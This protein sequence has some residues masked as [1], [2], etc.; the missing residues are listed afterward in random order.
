LVNLV[1]PL[2]VA[3]LD[4]ITQL[5]QEN[6]RLQ[7]ELAQ[8]RQ[9]CDRLQA[10]LAQ[11]RDSEKRYRTLFELS[12]EGIVRFGYEQPI[13]I[14]L[15][16]EEQVELCYRSIYIAEANNA[17]ARI[18]EYEKGKDT[19][20][21]TLNDFHDR[22]SEITQAA[23]RDWIE[24]QYTCRSVETVEIDRHGRKRYFLNSAASTIENGCV[25]CT[26]MSQ[27]DIT[28]LRE[29]QQA[30]LE[31]EQARVAE[32]VKANEALRNAIAGLARLDNLDSFLAEMLKV[33]L[34]VSGAHGGAVCLIEGDMVRHAVLFDKAGWV[35]PE[36][37]A[38]RGT[39]LL[40]FSPELRLM[41]QRILESE[42]AWA[43]LPDDPLHPPS[44]Q[45]F[46]RE[47]GN[48]A[49]R[50][51]PMRIGNRLLGWLGL[52]F[53][54]EDPPLGRS[55]A[56]LRVLAEQMT[57]AVEMLRLAEEA[58][59]SALAK[60]NEVIACEREKAAT[61]RAAELAKANDALRRGVERLVASGTLDAALDA[62]LLEAMSVTE[63]AA[64]AILERGTGSEFIMQALAQDGKI[65]KPFDPHSS[66]DLY[67]KRTA[68][69]PTGVMRRTAAGEIVIIPVEDIES[70]F[71]EA[72]AYHRNCGHRTV[73]HFPFQVGGEV[74]GF[75]G[76][77]FRE[78]KSPNDVL[79][80]TVQALAHQASLAL[81]SQRLA[82]RAKLAAIAQEQ[83]RAASERAAELAKANDALKRS[84][85]H[86]ISTDSLRSFLVAVL[87][88]AI[89][90]CDAVSAAVF[91][92]NQ[93][94][95]NLQ[96]IAL[97]LHGEAI[98]IATDPRAE[99]WR[100]PIPADL[101]DAW[102]VLSQ[103][104]RFFW[105]D[106]DNPGVE[107]WSIS[108]P[109]HQQ[110][111]HKNI[112]T[113][114]LLIGEQALGFLGLCFTTHQQPSE[115][116]LE[117]CW[118]LAQHAALALRMSQLAEEAK[119]AAIAKE[120]EKAAQQR[121][122]ELA[123]ANEELRQRDRLLSAVAQ[124][125][126]NLL[127][128]EDVETAIPSA[129][130][131]VGQAA[132]IS[133]VQLLLERQAP[134]KQKLQHIVAYEWNALGIAPQ[135]DH[136][137]AAVLDN[138][139]FNFMIQELHLGRSIWRLV[140]DFPDPIQTTFKSI[141]IESSGTVPIFIEGRYIGG[142]GFDDC[143]TAR[144]WSQQE[145]D[146]LTTAAESIGAALHRK[147]LVERLIHE[148]ARAA[149]ERAAQL[150]KANEA[151]KRSLT[152]LALEPSLDKLL[153]YVLQAI[154][155]SLG[156]RSGAVYLF[157]DSDNTT[158]L[159]LNYE[160]GQMQQ[161]EQIDHPAAT[162]RRPPKEWDTQ[163]LPLLRQNQ[164][165][166]HHESEFASPAYN[167]YR[168]HNAQRGI[169]TLL[170][171]PLLFGE[172]LL[173]SITLRSTQ[174]RNYTPEELELARAL[175]HQAT[176]AIQ[177]T[178]LAAQGCKQAILEERNR[179]ARDIHDS[180]AQA[181]TGIAATQPEAAQNCLSRARSLAASGLS[182]ARRSVRAL[183]PE[184]LES[185]D[186]PSA[187]YY[188]VE[189]MS[190]NTDVKITLQIDGTPRPIPVNVEINLLRIGQEALTNAVRHADAQNIRLNLLFEPEAVHLQIRD[191]GRG[192]QPQVQLTNG[193]FGLIGM[194]ERSRQIGGQLRLV[195]SIG[196][197]TEAIVT[198]PV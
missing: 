45:A 6:D 100:S 104:R 69:D 162:L 13:P 190:W 193:G 152:M 136:P 143:V 49:I 179:M 115:S 33:S 88:E 9:E 65:V 135:M 195:S 92:Y 122:A 189:Q 87:Q 81:E 95:H 124:V 23:M 196:R 121:A 98:D 168:Q 191:D 163:Y 19:I 161:G 26:W 171:V 84:I 60:L 15:P 63:A 119:Q 130:Q 75:L 145:I 129:L 148:R 156:D 22:N 44:F 99:I 157:D 46:H 103:E 30:L 10:E 181:F 117:Q 138:D 74:V 111:G 89:Q 48:R 187:L 144:Q 123:K 120:Q 109:W 77:A 8:L 55:F 170:F 112:A 36:V 68:A 175:A 29:A 94:S 78:A 25:V 172:Q 186:L 150:A 133:R 41:A 66:E 4:R 140:E 164:V 182:E 160:N 113:I 110:F 194:Q 147:Q 185:D 141:R 166:I 153:G 39:L 102:R 125:T 73:W 50:L 142:I 28:Q 180:L 35:S 91:V 58:K 149:E 83:E 70:W 118:T 72:A 62:F 42:D 82:E 176:L 59:Q 169:K 146:V 174:H 167:P 116:K 11:L 16:I 178:R 24:N 37:Q 197:G 126:K 101:T 61:Q 105:F 34:E 57:M 106:N 85:A 134:A 198:V 51:V 3:M 17:Y 97:I 67:R 71:P 137:T 86:L 12:S 139:E 183:R 40:P 18:F 27:V 151:L 54:Q 38:E 20:G 90:A 132:N 107:H 188:I 80:E 159:H 155:D 7:A 131:V 154:S 31:L 56:L 184:A 108:I 76:L 1:D 93:L 52:G 5:Q 128:A 165:L 96:N 114:P 43:V 2:H 53:A 32:L 79:R 173:G 192:F 127:E 177:L 47:Q 64:G 14:A 21:L 158:T